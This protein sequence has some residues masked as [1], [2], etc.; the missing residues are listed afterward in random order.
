MFRRGSG[1]LVVCEN[2]ELSGLR[3]LTGVRLCSA[4]AQNEDPPG[5]ETSEP[6]EDEAQIVPRRGEDGIDRI[7]LLAG[8]MVSLEQP[9]TLEMSNN[10][11]DGRTSPEFTLDR[12]RRQV[13]LA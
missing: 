7:A 4:I 6:G 1:Y 3:C 9:I 2:V 5:N 12:G 8:E 13:A 11:L 10:R